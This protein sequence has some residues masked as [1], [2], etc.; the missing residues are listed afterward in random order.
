MAAAPVPVE[1]GSCDAALCLSVTK[2]VHLNGG[3]AG[4]RAL[5]AALHAA[6]ALGGLLVLEPQPWRS[7]K[8]ALRKQVPLLALLTAVSS[9]SGHSS[10]CRMEATPYRV[11]YQSAVA[12]WS[13][14]NRTRFHRCAAANLTQELAGTLHAGTLAALQLRPDAF[15][16]YLQQEGGFRLVRGTAWLHGR[17][18]H[19]CQL[20][21]ANH[22][23]FLTPAGQPAPS[24]HVHLLGCSMR[25]IAR[26]LH[27]H[28]TMPRPRRTAP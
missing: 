23:V 17:H 20:V 7:Y 15:V 16:D 9:S 25:C 5:F 26:S 24:G 4:L 21:L 11:P 14:R 13:A 8:Q 22:T 27:G 2:W 10:V 12:F 19:A 6:L 18:C 1:A 3:D 28:L